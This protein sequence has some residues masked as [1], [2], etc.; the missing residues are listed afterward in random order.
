LRALGYVEATEI[1][2]SKGKFTTVYEQE[3]GERRFMCGFGE[4]VKM[5]RLTDGAY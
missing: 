4:K 5:V 3:P 2:K 1:P